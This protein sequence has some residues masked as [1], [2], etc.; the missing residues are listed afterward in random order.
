MT[1]DESIQKDILVRFEYLGTAGSLSVSQSTADYEW[2]GEETVMDVDSAEMI[3]TNGMDIMIFER[4]N[5]CII[6]YQDNLTLYRIY[7]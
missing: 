1:T 3:H 7:F 5:N 6:L 2:V 4:D